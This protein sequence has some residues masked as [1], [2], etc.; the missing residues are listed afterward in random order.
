MVSDLIEPALLII[1]HL[2]LLSAGSPA[3][4]PPTGPVPSGPLPPLPDTPARCRAHCLGPS[5][6]PSLLASRAWAAAGA[7]DWAPQRSPGARLRGKVLP[8]GQPGR[9]ARKSRQPPQHSPAAGLARCPAPTSGHRHLSLQDSNPLQV[10]IL[11]ASSGLG[12]LDPHPPCGPQVPA[13]WTLPAPPG[14]RH[15]HP[16]QWEPWRAFTSGRSA[17]TGSPGQGLGVGRDLP[18]PRSPEHRIPLSGSEP[19]T[20][21]FCPT[22]RSPAHPPVLTV[23]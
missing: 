13:R 11:Y 4:G 1:S 5:E 7:P 18:R 19:Q 3:H 10:C 16:G 9:P 21:A 17:A 6:A 22:H 15:S 23:L 14:C 12:F 2:C 20:A 8:V